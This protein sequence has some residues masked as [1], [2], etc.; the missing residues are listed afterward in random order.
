MIFGKSKAG[1]GPYLYQ[2]ACKVKISGATMGGSLVLVSAASE[3]LSKSEVC[4]AAEPGGETS[5][6]PMGFRAHLLGR[7][8]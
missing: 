6:R 2:G 8:V 7:C 1:Y 4:C 3:S 5:L